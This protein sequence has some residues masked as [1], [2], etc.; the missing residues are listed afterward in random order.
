MRTEPA[1]YLLPA[2]DH[3]RIESMLV[4]AVELLSLLQGF[5]IHLE[6][7]LIRDIGG[8]Q[9]LGGIHPLLGIISDKVKTA[10]DLIDT[11]NLTPA[12]EVS[13]D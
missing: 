12:E 8:R 9:H 13:R 4:D 5:V 6:T 2:A 1:A 10:S 3:E 11:V 7:S